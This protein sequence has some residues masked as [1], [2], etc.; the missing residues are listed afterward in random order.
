[1][2]GIEGM[3]IIIFWDLLITEHSSEQSNYL[4]LSFTLSHSLSLSST[5]YLGFLLQ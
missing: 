4:Q 2:K 5:T 1:M 3:I